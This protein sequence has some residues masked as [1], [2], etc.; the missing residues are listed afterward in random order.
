MKLLDLS[1]A[2]IP[3]L[4][5]L[6]FAGAIVGNDEDIEGDGLSMMT[7]SDGRSGREI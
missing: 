2:P 5:F 4:K 1:D 6:D 7:V 3:G